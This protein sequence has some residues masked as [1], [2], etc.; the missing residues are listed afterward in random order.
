MH[1]HHPTVY[2]ADQKMAT[3]KRT[4]L[5]TGCSDGSLG[6]YLAIAF[7]KAGLHVYATARNPSKMAGLTALGI[8]T[9]TLDV[10][11]DSS[12]AAAM[13]QIPSLDILVNN[14]G[15]VLNMPFSD[16]SIPEAKKLFDLNV[17]SYLAVTQAFLPLLL[18][19]K[20]I[21]A[22]QTSGA[23]VVTLPFQ[24]TYNASKA[25]MAMFSDS[26][27]LELEPF[28]IR[29]I[30][31][32]TGSVRS[33]I[34]KSMTE[35]TTLPKGS[36]YEPAREVVEKTLGGEELF[37]DAGE[38]TKWAEGVVGNLLKK[39][40]PPLIWLPGSINMFLIRLGLLLPFGTFDGTIKKM[41]GLDIVA[42]RVGK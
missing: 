35:R 20:G 33:N 7:H 9:L 17:W 30:D 24:S 21:I 13:A 23:S 18:E 3:P 37:K 12:I 1:W 2:M 6:S 16:L 41:T 11:S 4:V 34:Q 38:P 39:S 42:Q 14:A 36:I 40:P 22:N 28:G 15:A 5:I 19:S 31:L 8:E 32:K 29:V 25:A 10:L 27:R 26:Q